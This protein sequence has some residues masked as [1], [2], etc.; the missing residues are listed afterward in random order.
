MTC[1]EL[2]T[3]QIDNSENGL[4]NFNILGKEK[5]SKIDKNI[6]KK[7]LIINNEIMQ[8]LINIRFFK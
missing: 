4:K 5:D 6:Y 3:G 2:L 8:E 7:N 1:K